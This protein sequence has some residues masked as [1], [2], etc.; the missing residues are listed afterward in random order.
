MKKPDKASKQRLDKVESKF[1][2]ERNMQPV[3]PLSEEEL[4]N[5]TVDEATDRY[6][7]LVKQSMSK[8]MYEYL[9]SPTQKMSPEEASRI[10]YQFVK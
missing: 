8:E 3:P 10:Y 4:A 7:R 1:L 2:A 9:N 6:L 5:M